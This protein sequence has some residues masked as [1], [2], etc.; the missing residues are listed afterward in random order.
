[1]IT[2]TITRHV[3]RSAQDTFSVIGTGLYEYHPEWEREVVEIRPITS[4][5][6]GVGSRAVM[7][8]RDFGRT[9]ETEYEVT[10]FEQ[11]R[12]IAAHHNDD[13]SMDFRISFQITP[14]DSGSCSVQVDVAAQPLGWT[15]LAEPIM[16]LAMPRRGER[17]ANSMVTVIESAPALT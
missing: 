17:L 5:P 6:V 8:R 16:R 1:M 2:Q 12:R 4:D 14:I 7:V 15:K 9:T 13:P 10:E 11:D 3:N